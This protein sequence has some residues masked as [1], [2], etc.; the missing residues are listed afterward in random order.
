M[1]LFIL[2]FVVIAVCILGMSVG[3]LYGKTPI[4]GTCGGGRNIPGLDAGDACS[5]VC[6]N[7]GDKDHAKEKVC[8]NRQRR[9]QAT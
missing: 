3:V 1:A 7:K 2:T 8:P 4:K 9:K 6:G 5:G